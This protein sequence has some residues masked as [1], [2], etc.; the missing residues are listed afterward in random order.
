M[1]TSNV[2]KNKIGVSIGT[3][4]TTVYTSPTGKTAAIVGMSVANVAATPIIVSVSLTDTSTGLTA[5]LVK[6][7]P[8]PVGGALVVIGGDQKVVVEDGDSLKVI[9]DTAASADAILSVTELDNV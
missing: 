4:L 7:A 3:T 6:N 5:Y 2:F 8:V 9:S 1:A